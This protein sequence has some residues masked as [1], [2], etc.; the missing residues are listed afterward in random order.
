MAFTCIRVR[1]NDLGPPHPRSP[2]TNSCCCFPLTVRGCP[3]SSMSTSA[4]TALPL[5][6]QANSGLM[7]QMQMQQT[8]SLCWELFGGLWGSSRGWDGARKQGQTKGGR[9]NPQLGHAGLFSHNHSPLPALLVNSAG[10]CPQQAN[11]ESWGVDAG[12]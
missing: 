4:C 11:A 7:Q 1:G 12:P 9:S 6:P 2:N 5:A 3:S 8:L 10:F